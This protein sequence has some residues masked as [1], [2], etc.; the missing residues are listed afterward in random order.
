MPIRP[1]CSPGYPLL[2]GLSRKP[3]LAH[4]LSALHDGEV[5]I[6]AREIA[7]LAATTAAILNRASIV[8]VHA[9]RAAV[10][11]ARIADATLNAG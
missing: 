4:T 2:A 7:T 11:A 10:E 9:V 1:I 5:Y 6:E 8:R 3:F